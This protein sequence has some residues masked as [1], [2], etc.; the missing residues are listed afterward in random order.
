[1]ISHA[2]LLSGRGLPGARRCPGTGWDAAGAGHR[3]SPGGLPCHWHTAI[4]HGLSLNFNLHQTNWRHF[5]PISEKT[6]Q[7][8]NTQ[9]TSKPSKETK[10]SITSKKVEETTPGQNPGSRRSTYHLAKILQ[11]IIRNG[12][13]VSVPFNTIIPKDKHILNVVSGTRRTGVWAHLPQPSELD[14]TAYN[15]RLRKGCQYIKCYMYFSSRD[16]RTGQRVCTDS[17]V[18]IFFAHFQRTSHDQFQ[19]DHQLF[20]AITK[21]IH[22]CN[23][24]GIPLAL[25]SVDFVLWPIHRDRT[26]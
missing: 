5:S 12:K 3:V 22:T 13:L 19:T 10:R 9:P 2:R 26:S 20:P 6:Y 7:V 17:T 21:P 25:I 23:H 16:L 14:L 18:H 24:H 1:M 8:G 15:P 11:S 4:F